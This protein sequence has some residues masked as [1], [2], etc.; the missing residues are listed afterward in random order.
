[1]TATSVTVD[2]SQL[3][4]DKTQRDGALKMQALE[5]AKYPTATFALTSAIRIAEL[6]DDGEVVT[7]TVSGKLTLHG[8]TRDI[9]MQL[10]GVLD[11]NQLIVVGTTDIA[12]ADYNIAQPTS[13]AVLS[14]EDHGT[15]ELQLVFAKA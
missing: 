10:Q 13:M 9:T 1:V 11:G 12:F 7:Q 4:S 15:L 8:I 5:S 6:P 14:I 3:K 2:V